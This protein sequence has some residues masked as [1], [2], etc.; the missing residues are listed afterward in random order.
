VQQENDHD[1]GVRGLL[2]G[3]G[4]YQA[5]KPEVREQQHR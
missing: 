2:D 4:Q 1:R 5:P 3:V